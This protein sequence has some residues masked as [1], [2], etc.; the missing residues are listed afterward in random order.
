MDNYHLTKN[1]SGAWSLKREGAQRATQNFPG[2]T[3]IDAIREAAGLLRRT[4]D[5]ASLKIHGVKGRIQQERTYP[6]AADPSKSPG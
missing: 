5:A 2:K 1:E 6:R 4:P 3:K